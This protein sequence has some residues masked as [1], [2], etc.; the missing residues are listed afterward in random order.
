[1]NP[2]K[3]FIN[4]MTLISPKLK[5]QN[6][7]DEKNG[8][9]DS[10]DV[11]S[12]FRTFKRQWKY[13][14][15]GTGLGVI[16]AS[17][18]SSTLTPIYQGQFEIVIGNNSE[19]SQFPLSQLAGGS[20]VASAIIGK[21]GNSPQTETQ[22]A[23]LQSQS[24]LLPAYEEYKRLKG[25]DR[26]G[27]MPYIHWLHSH[28]KLAL[29]KDTT[30]LDVYY[31]D[32]DKSVVLPMT[33]FI[34]KQFVSYS[35][36]ARAKE[37][38]QSMAYLTRQIQKFKGTTQ[39]ST[40][41]A[42]NYGSTYGLTVQ[43]GLPMSGVGSS[44][45][46]GGGANI[47]TSSIIGSANSANAKSIEAKKSMIMQSLVEIKAHINY[48]SNLPPGEVYNYAS[49]QRNAET[50]DFYVKLLD[51]NSKLAEKES[52][53]RENDPSIQRLK[54]ER[55][56]LIKFIN[57]QEL[58][59]LKLRLAL[60]KVSLN[61][62][63]RPPVVMA[64]HRE[65]TQDALRNHATLS[66]LQDQYKTMQLEKARVSNGWEII[67][68]PKASNGPVGPNKQKYLL[69]GFLLGL[70]GG[71]SS[72]VIA[73][74]KRGLAFDKAE[75]QNALKLPLIQH[76]TTKN[77]DQMKRSCQLLAQGPLL[78]CQKIAFIR[79]GDLKL[80]IHNEFYS[81]LEK[82]I[83]N[84]ELVITDDV[85]ETIDCDL[86]IVVATPGCVT[87]NNLHKLQESLSLIDAATMGWILVDTNKIS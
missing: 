40:T 47:D 20:S 28:I 76:I 3:P 86:R 61:S 34:A 56:V 54:R 72:G 33:N 84:K 10:I 12:L 37:L 67:S 11:V 77:Q 85:T 69:A 6:T 80:E 43:D 39:E 38:D 32:S 55:D 53:F 65:L 21:A 17:L 66:S 78:N 82:T 49:Q 36:K 2:N 62:L 41:S 71:A 52:R 46:L 1:M 42:L 31:F 22:V 83:T 30:V 44:V 73:E 23:I 60:A 13:L 64:K 19:G 48:I 51:I 75:I 70:V 25:I 24:V 7:G 45:N 50:Q 81:V 68:P 87:F 35:T 26:S 59:S 15:S 58:S 18:Y 4:P 74:R 79:A 14:A 63:D 27:G 5:M 57:S 16:F 8:A 29:R 9:N